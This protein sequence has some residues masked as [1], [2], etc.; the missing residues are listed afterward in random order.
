MTKQQH[1]TKKSRETERER[2]KNE[3]NDCW[4]DDDKVYKYKYTECMRPNGSSP[5]VLTKHTKKKLKNHSHSC[6]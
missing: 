1:R 4:K 2:E 3:D 5:V 6:A